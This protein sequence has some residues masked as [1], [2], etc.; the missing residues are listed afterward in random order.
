[1]FEKVLC[2]IK[3]LPPFRLTHTL[4]HTGKRT[5]GNN[6]A[7]SAGDLILS[8]QKGPESVKNQG[9][10]GSQPVGK[11]EVSGSNPDSSSRKRLKSSDFRRFLF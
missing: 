2:R 6:G 10:E 9:L 7:K 3:F 11:D 8:E 5:D 1:M 4:T